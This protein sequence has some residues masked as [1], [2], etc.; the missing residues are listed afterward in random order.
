MRVSVTKPSQKWIIRPRGSALV[1]CMGD[2]LLGHQGSI[3]RDCGCRYCASVSDSITSLI[4]LRCQGM[5]TLVLL[6]VLVAA[7]NWSRGRL[8]HELISLELPL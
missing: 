1:L 8:L 5:R 2:L 7:T 4:G 6:K 3:P